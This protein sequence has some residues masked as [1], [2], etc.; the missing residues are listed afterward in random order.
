VGGLALPNTLSSYIEAKIINIKYQISRTIP[1]FRS[2]FHPLKWAARIKKTTVENRL[3][4]EY[5]RPAKKND[6][7]DKNDT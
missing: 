5:T 7:G 1:N 3:M 4:V 2:N 6:D